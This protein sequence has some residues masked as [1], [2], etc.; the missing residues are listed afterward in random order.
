MFGGYGKGLRIMSAGSIPDPATEFL[1]ELRPRC[2]PQFAHLLTEDYSWSEKLL[3]QQ[4]ADSA[5]PQH[6]TN[7]A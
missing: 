5:K 4:F 7:L 2:G 1:S 3:I 6:F